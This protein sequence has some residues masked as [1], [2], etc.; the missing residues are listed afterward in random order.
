MSTAARDMSRS[1]RVARVVEVVD[2]PLGAE[3]DQIRTRETTSFADLRGRILNTI[4]DVQ[5]LPV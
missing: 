1:E 3:R 5:T 2:V 4:R